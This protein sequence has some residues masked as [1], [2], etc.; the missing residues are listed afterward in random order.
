MI[1]RPPTSTR[2]Y[3]LFPYTTLCRSEDVSPIRFVA[4]PAEIAER[5]QRVQGAR[6]DG[7]GKAQYVRQ[8][9]HRMRAG[10]EIDQPH[11]GHMAVGEIRMTGPHIADQCLNPVI[12]RAFRPDV[13]PILA[14]VIFIKVN[15]P[16]RK[17]FRRTAERHE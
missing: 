10:G 11:Q 8:S 1:R 6:D 15:T 14:R 13:S 7:F 5:A 12:H 2:T 4:D 17:T 16:K 9:A 3:T